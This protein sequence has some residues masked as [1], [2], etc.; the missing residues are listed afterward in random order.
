[1]LG[2]F[3]QTTPDSRVATSIRACAVFAAVARLTQPKL[4]DIVTDAHGNPSRRADAKL[5]LVAQTK[6]RADVVGHIRQE[7]EY[8]RSFIDHQTAAEERQ[9][10]DTAATADDTAVCPRTKV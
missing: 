9:R 8:Y 7:R 4:G 2:C 1:M 5:L 3:W 10:H 6:L